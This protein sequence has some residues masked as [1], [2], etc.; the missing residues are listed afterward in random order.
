MSSLTVKRSI[1]VQVIVT[2]EFKSELK[3]ELQQADDA[4]QRRIDQMEFQSRRFLADLQRSDLTQAM[5]ARRQIE[6]E[7][8]RHEA[9]KQDI[10]RQLEEAEN[11]ALGSEYPRGTLEGVVEVRAGDDLFKKITG[12]EIVVKDGVIV[13]VREA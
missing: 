13:E 7:R 12:S 1:S 3:E 5:N 9:L 8:R 11:L 2:E 6:A 4:T 10:Q